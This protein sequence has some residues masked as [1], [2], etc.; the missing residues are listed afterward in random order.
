[1]FVQGQESVNHDTV[2]D[3]MPKQHSVII[4]F[5]STLS[6]THN[7][8]QRENQSLTLGD[9]LVCAFQDNTL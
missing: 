9:F 1:M 8:K 6:G 5:A 4:R 2:S 7:D 3:K